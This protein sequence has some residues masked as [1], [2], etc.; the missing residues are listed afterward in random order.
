[1]KGSLKT[2]MERRRLA[3]IVAAYTAKP[4][5]GSLKTKKRTTPKAVLFHQ[6]KNY[7]S[8]LRAGNF[9]LIR[10]ALPVK[11]RK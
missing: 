7:A 2:K 11:P 9:S 3:N 8:C 10:A 1:M 6:T 4:Q 5:K